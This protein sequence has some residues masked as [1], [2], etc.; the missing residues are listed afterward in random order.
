MVP[1]HRYT[2]Y[3]AQMITIPVTSYIYQGWA[4]VMGREGL[5]LRLIVIVGYLICKK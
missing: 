1:L 2:Y 4:I 3:F 5:A